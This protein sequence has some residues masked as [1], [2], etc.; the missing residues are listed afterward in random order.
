[1]NIYMIISGLAFGITVTF[2]LFIHVLIVSRHIHSFKNH[3]MIKFYENEVERIDNEIAIYTE[4]I[5]NGRCDN[6]SIIISWR[7]E[8]I[9]LINLRKYLIGKLDYYSK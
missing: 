5:H 2:V 6:N 7:R 1:M 8:K 4:L 3:E 9:H